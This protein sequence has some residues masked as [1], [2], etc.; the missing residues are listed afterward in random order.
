[1]NIVD[2]TIRVNQCLLPAQQV[3]LEDEVRVIEGVTSARFSRRIESWLTVTYDPVLISSIKILGQIK[4]WDK[5]A[6][7]F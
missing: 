7:M 2:I 5:N 6:A 4:Q 1:M 3:R